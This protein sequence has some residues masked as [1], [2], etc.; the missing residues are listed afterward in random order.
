M[1]QRCKMLK[2]KKKWQMDQGTR[3]AVTL[4]YECFLVEN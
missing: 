1:I 3:K 4:A 2:N